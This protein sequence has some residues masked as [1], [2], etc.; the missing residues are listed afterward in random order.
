M[1][2]MYL[3]KTKNEVFDKF[4]EF[5]VEFENLTDK[6][7]KTLRYDN[8]GEYTSKELISFCKVAGIKRELIIPHN[9]QQVKNLS[10]QDQAYTSKGS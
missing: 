7:I 8:G 5:K 6:K 2:W 4:Q 1:T 9:P 10:G 3:L